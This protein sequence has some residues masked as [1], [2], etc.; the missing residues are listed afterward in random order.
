MEISMASLG[1]GVITAFLFGFLLW[2]G[3]FLFIAFA[4]LLI[5]ASFFHSRTGKVFREIGIGLYTV[6][7]TCALTIF[8]YYVN[9]G[10]TRWFLIGAVLLSFWISIRF[11]ERHLFPVTLRATVTIRRIIGSILMKCVAPIGRGVKKAG[12]QGLIR[13]KKITLPIKKKYDKIKISI[14][15]K[16]KRMQMGRQVNRELSHLTREKD[17]NGH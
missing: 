9:H 14:Y 5:G 17:G 4:S 1:V 12:Y 11:F 8:L 6:F 15:D 7:A 13:I 16:K 3:R 2:G 10:I